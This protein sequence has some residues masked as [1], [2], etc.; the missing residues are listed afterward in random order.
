MRY[1]PAERADVHRAFTAQG[2]KA[3]VHLRGDGAGEGARLGVMRPTDAPDLG[4]VFA[5]RERVPDREVAV[6]QHRHAP[7]RR[8]LRDLRAVI[9][10]IELN[11]VLVEFEAGFAKNSHG[12]SD[13]LE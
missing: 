11:D 2:L 5:Y 13:Q 9:R 3:G 10:R 1:A 12:R 6:D 7:R 8:D 4:G